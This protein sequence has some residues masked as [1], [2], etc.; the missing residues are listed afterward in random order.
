LCLGVFRVAKFK[1][2]AQNSKVKI[3]DSTDKLTKFL[4]IRKFRICLLYWIRHFK[5]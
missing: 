5:F 3:A 4:S 1:S 2:E